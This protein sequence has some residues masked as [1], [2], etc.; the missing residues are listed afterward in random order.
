MRITTQ[1]INEGARKAGLPI[2]G[3]SLL[4]Y[5]KTDSSANTLLGAL[6]NNNNNPKVNNSVN[7]VKKSTYEKLE[8]AAEKLQ[9]K[10]EI[11]TEEGENSIFTKAKE[12]EDNQPIYDAAKSLVEQYNNTVKYLESS[13]SP[14]NDYYKQMF[15]EVISE[16]KESL[17]SIGISLSS[18]DTLSIDETKMKSASVDDLEKALGKASTFSDKI[19]F[20]ASRVS[21]NAETNMASLSS[22]YGSTGDIY[23]AL[24]NKFDLWG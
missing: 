1:M 13:S 2:H 19:A 6:S 7:S 10:A 20:I 4:D 5:I 24:N 16:N 23:S 11:F 17:A 15:E 8:K 3:N 9:E 12:S 22:T 21:A 14:L 18:K